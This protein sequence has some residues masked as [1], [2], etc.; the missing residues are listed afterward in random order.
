MEEK[1]LN[2][3]VVYILSVLGILC[4]CLAGLGIIP[5]GIAYFMAKSN[6]Q[7]VATDPEGYEQSQIKSMNT[8]RIIALVAII[9]NVLMII[10]VIY[11]IATV[12]WDEMYD[13]F[14]RAYQEALEA[15][16]Q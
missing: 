1:K 15:Q 14:S 4:C 10:R 13:E 11:V 6:L 16:G 9:I 7:K 2:P 12:G 3:A 8:A 5:S